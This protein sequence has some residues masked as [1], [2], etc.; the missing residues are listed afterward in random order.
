MPRCRNLYNPPLV[1][2]D[3]DTEISM[4]VR[5]SRV[6]EGLDNHFFDTVKVWIKDVW[7]FKL[8]KSRDVHNKPWK[9]FAKYRLISPWK[10]GP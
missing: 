8:I 6:A 1:P 3:F 10:D 7:P 2:D 9:Q 4:W 5:Q